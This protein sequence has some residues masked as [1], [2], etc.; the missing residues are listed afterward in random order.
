MF[1]CQMLM[2]LGMFQLAIFRGKHLCIWPLQKLRKLFFSA[3]HNHTLS[4]SSF[5]SVGQIHEM[6][7]D[8]GAGTFHASSEV[9]AVGSEYIIVLRVE[10]IQ[11]RTSRYVSMYLVSFSGNRQ[12]RMNPVHLSSVLRHNQGQQFLLRVSPQ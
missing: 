9:M 10:M 4:G 8:I 1:G 3:D 7:F 6:K 12:C 11:I 2:W 5:V